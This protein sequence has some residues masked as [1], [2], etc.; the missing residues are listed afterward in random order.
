[1]KTSFQHI[2]PFLI[3]LLFSFAAAAQNMWIDSVKKVLSTQKQ[4]TNRVYTLIGLCDAYSTSYPDTAFTY[5]KQAY[6]LSE[7]LD[8][9]NGRLYSLISL[10]AALFTMGNYTLELDYAFKLIPLAKRMNNLDATGF[11][12]GAVGDSYS[13]L[14]EYATALTY[15]KVVLGLG[16]ENKLP[17]LHRMYSM[18]TPVFLGLKQYDSAMWYAKKG[19]ELFK[20][21]AYFTSN[22]W[23]TRWSESGT[24]LMLAQAYACKGMNDSALKFYRM[25]IPVSENLDMKFNWI[26]ACN[27]MANV[28]KQQ[29]NFDSAKWYAQKI[30]LQKNLVINPSGRQKAA[31]VLAD[32]YETEH[33]SDSALKYLHLANQ[34]KDSLYNHEKIMAFQN[35]QLKQNEK[36]RAVEAATTVLQ[37]RYRLYFII[38]AL[39][40]VFAA[41][42]MIIRNRRIRQLQNIRNSIA[43]DLHDDIS[44]TLSSISIMN[45]LAKEKSPEALLLL[46]SIGENTSAI[47]ENMNDIVWTVNPK[48]D[49]FENV[50]QRMHLFATEILDAKNIQLELNNDASL[51]NAKLTMKQRKNL[52]LFYKEAVNNAAK[53]SG[54]KKV[55]VNIIKKEQSIEMNI[56]DNG[57]GFNTSEIFNGNGMNSLKKRVDELNG[58]Y[59]IISQINKGTTVQLKFKIT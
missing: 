11:S 50:L 49:H 3:L 48:N 8:F 23:N 14:G 4:D 38:T 17:E 51:N 31:G 29:H 59:N 1:M 12:N 54:A 21:S 53:H 24:Y 34:L 57:S 40:I 52:Y 25:S 36:E 7:K 6:E 35:V 10:N 18:M 13:S 33:N 20:T 55:T 15:Y 37:N 28:F 44:S 16:I 42:V 2:L 56:S 45:E 41:I 58:M 19:Y 46:S 5:G 32:I 9:D 47:Q 27:G 43:D 30:L 39:V 22:D 26:D